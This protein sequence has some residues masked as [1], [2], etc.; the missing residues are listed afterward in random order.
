MSP[1]TAQHP[2]TPLVRAALPVAGIT[3]VVAVGASALAAGKPGL[4]GS[5]LGVALAV[6]Y[7]GLSLLVGLLTLRRDPNVMMAAAMA[8]FLLKL[9]LLMVV[10]RS[11]QASGVFDSID[12]MAFAVTAAALALATVVAEAIGFSRARRPV[13]DSPVGKG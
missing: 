12:G 13:W 11:L 4:W 3:A 6:I 1:Q 5:L 7:L 8:S 2:V 9:V 10:L